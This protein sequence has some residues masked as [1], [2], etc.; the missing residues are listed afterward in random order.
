MSEN[1]MKPNRPNRKNIPQK[2]QGGV[3][4]T[5]SSK[6][7]GLTV[8]PPGSKDIDA[9]AK[10]AQLIM[11]GIA[12]LAIWGGI[13]SIAFA[14]NATNQNFLILGIGG[15]VSAIMALA[16]VE[17]QRKK[18]GDGLHSVHDYLLGVGF[19]FAAV[20]VLWGSRFL[21]GIAASNGVEWL[22]VEGIP[23]SNEDWS[24]SANGI[25]VQLIACTALILSEYKYIKGLKGTTSFGWSIITF[26]P[27]ALVAAGVGPWLSWSGDIVSW[28]LGISI[29]S[30]SI[31]SMWLA[32]ESNN[33]LI[34]SI[35]SVVAGL[36]PFLYEIFNDNAT[37]EG[38]GGALSL[39]IFIIIGQGYLAAD[40]RLRKGL[41]ELTSLFLIAEIVAA[42]VITREEGLNLILGP[43]REANL[44]DA[45]TYI[46]L[47]SVLWIT[48]LLAYFPAVHKQRIPWMPIGLAGSIWI[49]EPG[50][51]VVAWSIAL[52][53]LPYM[54]IW[55]KATRT[56]VANATLIA[57][58]C[59]F[60][61]QDTINF[62]GD[63][64]WI[65]AEVVVFIAIT[66]IVIGEISRT[67]GPLSNWAHFISLGIIVLSESIL[68]EGGVFVSWA[69]ILYI[70]VSSW[71]MLHNASITNKIKDRLEG[72]IALFVSIILTIIFSEND[73]L[74]LP[75]PEN[76]VNA[77]DGFNIGLA[78]LAIIIWISIRRFRTIELDVGHLFH[79]LI[80]SG[81]KSVPAYDMKNG[82]WS[83]DMTEKEEVWINMGWGS[84]GRISL[85]GPLILLSLSITNAIM[86]YSGNEH[87][88]V[89]LMALPLGI[90]LWELVESEG[91]SSK[92]RAMASWILVLICLPITIE[93]N[94]LRTKYL[95]YFE[96]TGIS[97]EL[98]KIGDVLLSNLLFDLLLILGPIIVTVVLFKR[99]LSSEKLS[100]T[101]D[102]WAYFGLLV[103]A[104]LD[105]SGGLAFVTLY[106]IV[107]FNAIKYRHFAVLVVAP[108]S[109]LI[110]GDNMVGEGDFIAMLL[111]SID[112]TSYNPKEITV[113]EMPR[114]SC[115]IIALTGIAVLIKSMIDSQVEDSDLRE[116]PIVA[117]SIWL[118]IGVWG[119]LPNSAWILLIITIGLTLQ[120]WF[121]GKLNF[122]PYAPAAVVISLLSG[123]TLDQNFEN[124]TG[125]EI[126]SYGLLGAGLYSLFLHYIAKTSLLYKWAPLCEVS[127]EKPIIP[128]LFNLD[129]EKGRSQLIISL[130]YWTMI[131]LLLSWDA[132]L[133]FG[134]IIGA[135]WI[136]WEILNNGQ[137]DLIL[138]MPALQAFA[139][140]NL[141][142][143]IG[144]GRWDLLQDIVV[145]FVL[146]V[147]G[148]GFT[149]FSSKSEIVWNLE[150]FEF[151]DE[152]EYFDWLDRIGMMSILYIVTGIL[153]IM[154]TANMDSL[155]WGIISIYLST[156]AIQGFQEET[157][158]GWRRS[159]GGFGSI[160]SLFILSSTIEDTLYQS[161]TWLALGIVA[162]G[163]GMLY[164]QKFGDQTEVFV[165]EEGVAP[166]VEEEE[167][168]P[169]VEEEEVAPVVEEEEV[170]PVV[171]SDAE[172]L[173]ETKDGFFFRLS[174]GI[175][176]NIRTALEDT[177][178]E[179]FKPVLEFN[180]NGQIVLNFE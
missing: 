14:E 171:E 153:W 159:I 83:V 103:L 170:A 175:M 156:V 26:T 42:I 21:I 53:V 128:S 25:Y 89:L 144:D 177:P 13:L 118:G 71:R 150:V 112:F 158:S 31:L 87:Y 168:A 81:K 6:K 104:L 18:G 62:W 22:L 3:Y 165:E 95:D 139:L 41:M 138:L 2:P 40:N 133:G 105:T 154:N 86:G 66:L 34:F 16:L 102:M 151:E 161:I 50:S 43:I 140:W 54:L 76:I 68:F 106:F 36:V 9:L 113:L 91:A 44:G 135:I 179:G 166:V 109:L 78:I 180:S 65:G 148:I 8:L 97:I 142:N 132:L 17:M 172:E 55:A 110:A 157:D 33:G 117:A 58:A 99:G 124:L 92:E 64:D 45:A 80:D 160:L 77:I 1:K 73:R 82:S 57:A 27:L 108:L 88:W 10:F 152:K 52:I 107:I 85:I 125:T 114:F 145:G 143:Q 4:G 129:L 127:D 111:N 23:F 98:I 59:S 120:S 72:S 67:V 116:M 56:W 39:L 84:I 24:P 35:V 79:W 49:L 173:I 74:T 147:E 32:L 146:I 61:I 176:D 96:D 136:S 70:I 48:V 164:M 167:V 60:F 123:L 131:C 130:Q 122:I 15:V 169:V 126:L 162:F 63:V 11:Y 38:V 46:N 141:I 101:A 12:M 75:L 69:L 94:W 47:Q 93:L 178:H 19:F 7:V 115:I 20:G 155:A 163:F 137:K 28:E 174:P 121:T 30:M 37:N 29:V 90:L 51:S 119:V 5:S 134:T 100:Y 149:Y